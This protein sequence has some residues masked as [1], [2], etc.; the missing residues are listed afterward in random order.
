MSHSCAVLLQYW[1]TAYTQFIVNAYISPCYFKY[2][3]VQFRNMDCLSFLIMYMIWD[4]TVYRMAQKPHNL[5]TVYI[6][7]AHS[8]TKFHWSIFTV[9]KSQMTRTFRKKTTRSKAPTCQMSY[10]EQMKKLSILHSNCFSA[11]RRVQPQFFLPVMTIKVV[12]LLCAFIGRTIVKNTEYLLLIRMHCC[13]LW[14]NCHVHLEV[15]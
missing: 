10:N 14:M 2:Y 4:A 13:Q 7:C 12:Q 1:F 9:M 15:C 6:L 11:Y 3:V 5:E 8:V